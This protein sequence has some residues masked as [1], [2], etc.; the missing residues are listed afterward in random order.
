MDH[1]KGDMALVPTFRLPTLIH[2][3]SGNAKYLNEISNKHPVWMNSI[4]ADRLGLQTGDMV[5]VNTD[6]GYF[7]ARIWSTEGIKPGDD[8]LTAPL[9]RLSELVKTLGNSRDQS[10]LTFWE[11]ESR[12]IEN[13]MHKLSDSALSLDEIIQQYFLTQSDV[14]RL[15]KRVNRDAWL[16]G[17]WALLPANQLIALKGFQFGMTNFSTPSVSPISIVLSVL[18]YSLY[19]IETIWLAVFVLKDL[20]ILWFIFIIDSSETKNNVYDVDLPALAPEADLFATLYTR[21]FPELK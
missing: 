4:D 3:R 12:F 10:I 2:T 13:Q 9:S 1:A 17:L 20:E 16:K 15:T 14:E 5:R 19:M 11:S 6:I 18:I 7:V 8:Y 21:S